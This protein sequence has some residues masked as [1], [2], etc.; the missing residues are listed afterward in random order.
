MVSTP[1]GFNDNSQ[2][3][4]GPS[5]TVKNPSARKSLCKCSRVLNFKQNAAVRRLGDAKP[6]TKEIRSINMLWFSITK[7]RGNKK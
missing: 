6:N 1:D 3:L 5:V 2:N 4:L 7:K